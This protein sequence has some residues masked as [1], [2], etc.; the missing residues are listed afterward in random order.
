MRFYNNIA[1]RERKI[2]IMEKH[3]SISQAAKI[4]GVTAKTIRSW[5]NNG[6][7]TTI[8]TPG[9]QRRIPE[10]EIL[11]MTGQKMQS[12]EV[13]T[14]I[15]ASDDNSLILMC[16]NIEIYNV[17]K[18]EVLNSDLLPGCMKRKTLSYLQWMKTRYSVGSN[19]SARRLMLSAFGSD[20]HENV[21]EAT[22][23]LSL[24]DCYWLKRQNESVSF[25][26]ITPYIHKEWDGSGVFKGGSISTLFVN[27]AADKKWIDSKTLL[28]VKSYKEY[29]AY[30]LCYT[31]GLDTVAQAKE[32]DE[33]ILLTNF[34]STDYFLESMEQSGYS[35]KK[36]NPREKAVEIFKEQ[37]VALFVVDYLVE[38][39]DRHWGNYGFLRDSN[40]GEY[41]SMAPYY[42]FDWSWSSAVVALPD[43][44]YKNHSDLIHSLC[45]KALNI[46][47]KFEHK[48]I[49]SKRAIE[50]LGILL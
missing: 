26:D 35:G 41:I 13:K 45:E 4:L 42:D 3:Y 36:D 7:I 19:V 39:D 11:R 25:Y 10:S 27:G 30:S 50:L 6:I 44:A 38:H 37:A 34:T 15:K 29:E 2:D 9:N 28:K 22:R 12:K 5:D 16:K 47:H 23:T 1:T 49:I 14:K 8:R 21:I 31:L 17:T 24:S 46:S 33:G 20:N 18:N 43:N 40:T 32:S 48:E